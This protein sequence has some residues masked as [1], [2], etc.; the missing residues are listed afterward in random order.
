M[1]GLT[2]YDKWQRGIERKRSDWDIE[3]MFDNML[4]SFYNNT[5]FPNLLNSKEMNMK[6]DI[7]E[8]DKEYTLE[9]EMPGAKKGEINLNLKDDILTISWERKNEVN[10]EKENYIRKERSY[11]S[12]SRSFYV[13]DVDIEKSTAKFEDGVLVVN[14]P[15]KEPSSPKNSTIKIQ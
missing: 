6:V 7:K 11:G 12:T 13:D 5:P 8:N 9:A 10:E 3:R 1:F 14:L 4:E 15:K 2:P